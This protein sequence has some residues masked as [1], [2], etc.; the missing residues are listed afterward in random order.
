MDNVVGS[1]DHD[2]PRGGLV[3]GDM[4]NTSGIQLVAAHVQVIGGGVVF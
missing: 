3:P 4:N 1:S 2:R